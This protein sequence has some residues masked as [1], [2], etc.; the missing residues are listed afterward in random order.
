LAVLI[1][2]CAALWWYQSIP[3]TQPV[4]AYVIPAT[5]KEVKD[6]IKQSVNVGTVKAYPAASKKKL[7]L[8]PAI[9]QD[10]NQYVVS[11]SS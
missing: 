6:V 5:A 8:P 4:S 9:V 2:I 11:A 10:D 3:K 7:G 1:L